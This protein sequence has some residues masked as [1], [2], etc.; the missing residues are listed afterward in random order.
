MPTPPPLV[1]LP[2]SE[3]E[4]VSRNILHYRLPRTEVQH[5]YGLLR[6]Y[7]EKICDA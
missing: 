5:S 4:R 2:E 3:W 7:F 1:L 6:L